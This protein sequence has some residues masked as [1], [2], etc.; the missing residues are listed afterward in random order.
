M[1]ERKTKPS[2]NAT[3]RKCA[4]ACS[5]FLDG[6]LFAAQ[7]MALDHNEGG[8]AQDIIQSSGFSQRDML[9][10]QRRSGYESR[11][12][13]RLIRRAIPNKSVSGSPRAASTEDSMVGGGS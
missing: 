3:A 10:A 8:F 12:M 11:T 6:V 5:G 4:G 1:S 13:C 2:T 7:F 9:R